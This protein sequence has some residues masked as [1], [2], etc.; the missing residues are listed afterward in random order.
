MRSIL[1]SLAVLSLL[2]LSASMSTGLHQEVRRNKF[3]AMEVI[4]ET[5][6]GIKKTVM[7]PLRHFTQDYIRQTEFLQEAQEQIEA[8][9]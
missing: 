4:E 3:G 9:N 7:K 1:P 2:G 6:T 8:N 5:A